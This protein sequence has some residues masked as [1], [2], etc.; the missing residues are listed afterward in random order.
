MKNVIMLLMGFNSL[1]TLETEPKNNPIIPRK[2][3]PIS[4][5]ID[6]MAF[7]VSKEESN[8]N[9]T[10]INNIGCIG[11]YQFHKLALLD[12]G[13]DM[14]FIKRIKSGDFSKFGK[15]VQDSLFRVFCLKSLESCKKL[16]K[17]LRKHYTDSQ[18]VYASMLGNYRLLRYLRGSKNERDQNNQ[19]IKYRLRKWKIIT[20]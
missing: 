3:E 19:T 16:P 10:A 11:A 15:S 7:I 6:T 13:Y 14:N 8:C 12:F 2:V 5:W 18:L 1:S 9:Y 4:D 17:R 20:K